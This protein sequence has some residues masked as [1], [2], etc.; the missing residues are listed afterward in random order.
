MDV[1][2]IQKIRCLVKETEP[3]KTPASGGKVNMVDM[4]ERGHTEGRGE[5]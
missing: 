4:D 2:E 1:G 5:N 3:Y